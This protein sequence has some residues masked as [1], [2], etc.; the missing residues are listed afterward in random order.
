MISVIN[1]TF[2]LALSFEYNYFFTSNFE[3]IMIY[4]F[5]IFNKISNISV[6]KID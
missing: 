5:K 1:I 2:Q 4:K 6:M 3:F